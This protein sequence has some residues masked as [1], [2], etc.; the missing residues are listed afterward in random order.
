MATQY[1][2]RP[3]LQLFGVSTS[4]VVRKIGLSDLGDALRGLTMIATAGTAEAARNS[5]RFIAKPERALR[6]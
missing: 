6:L 5:R 4:F 3:K 1:F 2:A